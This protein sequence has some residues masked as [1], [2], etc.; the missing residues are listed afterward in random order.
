MVLIPSADSPGGQAAGQ[1]AGLAL[2]T[3]D[4]DVVSLSGAV[5]EHFFSV[6][7]VAQMR[8]VL[9]NAAARHVTVV[10][11]SGDAGPVSDVYRFG[12]APVKEVSLP[13]S[14]PL[15][16]GVGGTSLMAAPHTGSYLAESAW[17]QAVGGRTLASGGG[18]SRIF[19]R[20]AYQRGVPATGTTRAVPDVSGDADVRMGMAL[21]DQAAGGGY[22]LR[23]AGGT[24]AA[25]PLWG[26]LI[27]LADQ[28]AGRDLGSVDPSLYRIAR[29][30]LYDLAFHDVTTGTNTVTLNGVTYSGYQAGAGWDAV[31]GLG[32]PDAAMLVPLLAGQIA[33]R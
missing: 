12:V 31:T 7:Q 13:S 23:S 1:I 5:G 21:A 28:R 32:T 16:L 10:A 22:E 18:F 14:D 26:G 11:A 3:H 20:P 9:R 2:A 17:N 4:T 24:S 30:P 29:S 25:T 8:D 33:W 6:A 15:V 27:A 19:A